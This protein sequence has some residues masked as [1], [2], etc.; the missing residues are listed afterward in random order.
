M[1]KLADASSKVVE[2]CTLSTKLA[3]VFSI[4]VELTLFLFSMPKADQSIFE[5]GS[6]L[7]KSSVALDL[8]LRISSWILHEP[9]AEES[10]FNCISVS[11]QV[12]QPI[13]KT[14]EYCNKMKW[15][16]SENKMDTIYSLFFYLIL[17]W[18][19]CTLSLLVFKILSSWI[20]VIKNFQNLTHASCQQCSSKCRTK[21]SK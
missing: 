8:T 20:L 4:A 2:L 19:S 18:L 12:K 3:P 7:S 16:Y 5:E 14:F 10:L 6:V 1:V 11:A 9:V 15:N 21:F 17:V 13:H